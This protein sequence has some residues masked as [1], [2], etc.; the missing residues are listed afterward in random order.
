MKFTKSNENYAYFYIN[1]SNINMINVL[2]LLG[3][4]L[5]ISIKTLKE[6]EYKIFMKA[7][8]QQVENS[9]ST[10]TKKTNFINLTNYVAFTISANKLNEANKLMKLFTFNPVRLK[11]IKEK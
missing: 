10:S 3:K 1:Y 9:Y 11:T 4:S 7:L 2:E 6:K 8:Y 5:K